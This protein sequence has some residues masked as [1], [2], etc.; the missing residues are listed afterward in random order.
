MT[1][2]GLYGEEIR[3]KD[4]GL[5]G[6]DSTIAGSM[7]TMNKAVKIASELVGVPLD[8]AIAM[9]TA[10]PA[11][12]AGIDH[13]KGSLE[14]GKDADIVICDHEFNVRTVIIRGRVVHETPKASLAC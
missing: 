3:V 11:F 8:K 6:S 12:A 10:N 13:Y 9:A 14:P 1:S 5:Y 4:G 2:F 7:L